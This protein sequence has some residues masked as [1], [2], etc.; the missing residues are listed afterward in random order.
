MQPVKNFES[1]YSISEDGIILNSRGKVLKPSRSD[2]YHIIV[3][4]DDYGKRVTKGVH[5]LVAETYIPN[6]NGHPQVN[7]I[8]EN[9][10]NN[11]VS[12]LQWCTPQFNKE[13]SSA[14]VYKFLNPLG[15]IVEIY[16]LTKFCRENGLHQP[17]MC[18]LFYGR[19]KS[20]KGWKAIS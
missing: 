7:H 15:E 10:S 1:R 16:N 20:S 9:K 13:Y 17:A 5:R 3:L 12:N 11:S 4:T 6:P 18:A 19:N 8:D 2:G 14:K